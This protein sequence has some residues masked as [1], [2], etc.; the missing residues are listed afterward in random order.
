MRVRLTRGDVD[1]PARYVDAGHVGHAYAMTVN[2]AHGLTCDRTM[3]LGDDQIYRELAYEALS[4][5]RLS[6]QVY[7]PRS[8]VLDLR[9]RLPHARTVDTPDPMETLEQGL[10]RRHAKHLAL[11]GMATVP[12]QAWTTTDLLAERDRIRSVL[13]EAPPDRSQDLVALASRAATRSAISARPTSTSPAS[14][15]E[16]ARSVSGA[17][18]TSS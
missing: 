8:C 16:S 11:D 18:P 1:L 6:N 9:R 7:I 3:T 14:N 15:A 17:V 5:G 12:L 4:R 2:K 13:A 10:R